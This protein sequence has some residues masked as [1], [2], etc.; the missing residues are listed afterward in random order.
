MNRLCPG[1]KIVFLLVLDWT[2]FEDE[3]E[4]DSRDNT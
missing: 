4:D 2:E 3:I 1:P